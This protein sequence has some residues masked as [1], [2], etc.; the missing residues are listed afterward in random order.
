MSLGFTNNENNFGMYNSGTTVP[1]LGISV[2]NYGT[3]IGSTVGT[4]SVANKS[5]GLVSDPTKSGLIVETDADLIV[6][7]KF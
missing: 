4:G 1:H 3:P 6:C 5:V 2:S 7:I